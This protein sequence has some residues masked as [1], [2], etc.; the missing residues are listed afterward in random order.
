ML[1][2][3]ASSM[4]I[5][6][7]FLLMSAG[8]QDDPKRFNAPRW[9]DDRLDVCMGIGRDCGAS[10]ANQF[11]HKWRFERAIDFEPERVG[12]AATTRTMQSNETCSD[13]DGCTAFRHITCQGKIPSY[14]NFANPTWSAPGR[15]LMRLD[16]CMEAG[17][18]QCGQPVADAFCRQKEYRRALYWQA[19]AERG[20][21]PTR[22][23]RGPECQRTCVGFGVITCE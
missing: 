7:S 22:R 16:V 9:G 2:L 3:L 20:L 8:G 12:R 11:C 17:S 4:A 15:P 5:F 1:R 14:R 19:D 13:D 18:N 6:G 23:I 10:V 21:T